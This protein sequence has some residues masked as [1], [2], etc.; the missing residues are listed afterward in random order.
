MGKNPLHRPDYRNSGANRISICIFLP[1]VRAGI[2]Q[3]SGDAPLLA[4]GFEAS[5]P[6]DYLREYDAF[7]RAVR[8][9]D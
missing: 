2:W 9:V 8:R 4:V 7:L 3:Y 1:A 5:D 6:E